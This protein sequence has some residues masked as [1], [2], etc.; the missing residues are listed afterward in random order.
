MICFMNYTIFKLILKIDIYVIYVQLIS[1]NQA[2]LLN[3]LIHIK[4]H[5]SFP[6][7][8]EI[9]KGKILFFLSILNSGN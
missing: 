8:I 6:W 2:S 3:E 4:A 9:N 5:S 1:V 7:N